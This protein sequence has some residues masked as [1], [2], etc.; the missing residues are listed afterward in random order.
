MDFY[1]RTEELWKIYFSAGED[2]TKAKAMDWLAPN[3]VVI[4]TGA[5]EFYVGKDAFLQVLADEIKERENISFQ[6]KDIWCEQLRCGPDSCLV[7]GKIHVWWESEDKIVRIDM[8]SRFSFL[9]HKIDGKWKVV[10]IHQSIPNQEQKEGEYYPKTLSEKIEKLQSVADEM[11]ELAKK[12]SM[13]GL[14]NFRTFNSLWRQREKPGWLFIIDIDH[15]KNVNDTYGHVAGN[16]VIIGIAGVLQE[17]VRGQD[18]VCRMG[19]DEFLIFCSGMQGEDHA[20]QFASRILENIKKAGENRRCWA[21]VSIGGTAAGLDESIEVALARAD[22]SL[23]A[24]KRTGR[25][26]F[27]AV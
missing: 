13:T 8:D 14:E 24:V 3:C 25:G 6:F 9:Y 22:H 26:N 7:Y 18:L 1:K 12:D 2:E 15:F 4:G 16:E 5:H 11:T 20:A 17:A 27:F 21:T 10:H 19:G 23:Y